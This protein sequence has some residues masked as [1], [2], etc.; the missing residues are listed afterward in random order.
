MALK[1]FYTFLFILIGILAY[2]VYLVYDAR[3]SLVNPPAAYVFGPEDADLTV[4][5]FIDYACPYCRE[6]HPTFKEAMERDGRVRLAPRPLMSSNA[7]GTGAA[8]IFYAAGMNGKAELAHDYLMGDGGVNLTEE[9]LPEIA[10][11]LGIELEKFREDLNSAEPRDQI[12]RN[13]KT[14]NAYGGTGTPTFFI[15]PDLVYLSDGGMPTVQDFLDLFDEAR[16]MQ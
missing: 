6:M 2:Q 5:E 15:G 10:E 16:A 4:T 3:S 13:Y 1:L 14:F 7:D 12:S 11:S 9:R 8:Y